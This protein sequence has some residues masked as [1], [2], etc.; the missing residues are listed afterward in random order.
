MKKAKRPAGRKA[1]ASAAGKKRKP[2]M[3]HG[4]DGVR[5][6]SKRA[7]LSAKKA[8]K[9]TSSPSPGGRG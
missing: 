2:I 9:P 8:A 6:V 3:R 5:A 7:R 1:A 4:R